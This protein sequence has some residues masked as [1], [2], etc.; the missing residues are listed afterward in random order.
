VRTLIDRR[1]P[2]GRHEVTWDGRL[3]SGDLATCGVYFVKVDAGDHSGRSKLL[4]LR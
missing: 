2:G 4:V 3:E 1:L